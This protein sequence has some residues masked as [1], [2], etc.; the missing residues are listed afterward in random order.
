MSGRP[1]AAAGTR[2]AL[3][4][5]GPTNARV[6]EEFQVVLQL[7]SQQGITRLRSQMRFDASALQLI[8]ATVGDIVP[9]AAG[10]PSVDAKGGG[11]QLDVVASP[12]DPVQGSGSLMILRFKALAVRPATSI[13]AMANVLGGTGAA[14][15]ST[16]APPLQVAIRQ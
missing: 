8:S 14:I 3:N 10:G 15:G 2:S 6:G 11:A 16:S 7:S 9:A 4:L 12:E 13:A 5:V 1:P